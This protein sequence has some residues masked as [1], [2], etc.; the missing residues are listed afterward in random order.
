MRTLVGVESSKYKKFCLIAP[1]ASDKSRGK[2]S[3]W[4]QIEKN[5]LFVYIFFTFVCFAGKGTC[6][7]GSL[8]VPIGKRDI[9]F[10]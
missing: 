10:T 9:W 3:L 6:K 1:N 8:T 4:F 5:S 2:I 7:L